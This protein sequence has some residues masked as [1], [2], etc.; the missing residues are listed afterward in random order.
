MVNVISVII[1]SNSKVGLTGSL[2]SVSARLECVVLHK[3]PQMESIGRIT[4]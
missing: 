4:V 2:R 3:N 1:L